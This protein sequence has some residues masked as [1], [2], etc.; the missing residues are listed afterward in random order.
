MR[1]TQLGRFRG[2][3]SRRTFIAATG[4]TG[5][6]GLAGCLGDDTDG[7]DETGTTESDDTDGETLSGEVT[8]TGSSTVYPISKEMADRFMAAHPDVTVRVEPT[9]SGGGFEGHFCPGESDINGASRPITS[10]E[11]DHCGE[12]GV[13]TLELQIAGDALTMAISTENTWADCLSFA[14]LAR[15]WSENGAETW[16][17][18]DPDW[19]AEPF[20]R[21]G[22]DTTSGTYDWFTETVVSSA[23]PHRS[24]YVSTEDDETIVQGLEES[25]YAIGYFGYSYY[26]RNADRIDALRV[27]RGPD[28][29]CAEPSLGAARDGTY[30]MARPLFIY[31]S[32]EA[33]AREPVAE[34]V[35][36]YLENATA[37]WIADD[38]GY[39]PS[40]DDQSETNLERLEAIVDD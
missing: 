19:P 1:S 37:D 7:A 5:L 3:I 20:E 26:A 36:F 6:T 39:V 18:L 28:D 17:D 24:D 11:T 27:K 32:E 35:R 4:G 2:G 34:F 16:A 21:Y 29:S 15:I 13:T 8:V 22:P 10:A 9:G 30:P 14:E 38:I 33:L 40:S 12:N 25:P 23:G 31:P